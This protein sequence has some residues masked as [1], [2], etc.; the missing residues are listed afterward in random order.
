MVSI[1]SGVSLIEE[2]QLS[3]GVWVWIQLVGGTT[4][5]EGVWGGVLLLDD[6]VAPVDLGLLERGLDVGC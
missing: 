2:E 3:G 4:S 5:M 1:G 6:L